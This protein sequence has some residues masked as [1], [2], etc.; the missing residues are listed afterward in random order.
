MANAGQLIVDLIAE[1]QAFRAD[2]AKASSAAQ[3]HMGSISKSI[4]GV[5]KGFETVTRVAGAFGV[6]LGAREIVDFIGR[7]IDAAARLDDMA[8]EAGVTAEQLQ[9]LTYAATQAGL[10]QDELQTALT[11]LTR[12]I[13]EA[14]N[15]SKQAIDDFD[16]LGISITDSN[17]RIRPTA[18]IYRDV[19]AGLAKIPDPAV[20][21]R[22]ETE[23]FGKSGQKLDQQLRQGAEGMDV[24][25]QKARELGLVLSDEQI[26]AMKEA[27]DK[28]AEMTLKWE[29]FTERLVS[30]VAPAIS[31]VLD[32]LNKI[33]TNITT[34]YH[35]LLAGINPGMI[36]GDITQAGIDAL[37]GG[38][39]SVTIPLTGDPRKNAPAPPSRTL[40]N[41]PEP[42]KIAGGGSRVDEAAKMVEQLRFEVDMLDKTALQQRI[43]NDLRQA[44]TTADTAYGQQI[45]ALDTQLDAHEKALKAAADA[46]QKKDELTAEGQRIH[47]SVMTPL[48][49]Y[50]AAI[51]HLSELLKAGAISQEDYNR[52]AAQLKASLDQATPAAE[53]A[54]TQTSALGDSLDSVGLSFLQ[55]AQSAKTWQDVLN[56]AINSVI[57]EILRLLEASQ[58]ASGGGGILGIL[59]SIGS[60]IGGL[61]GGGG[62]TGSSIPT[63][64]V[65]A[66]AFGGMP[67]FASGGSFMVGGMGG[68]DSNVIQF[69]ASRG[70]RVSIETPEQ[71]RR[72]HGG[73]VFAPTFNISTPDADSFRRSQRQI[74]GDGFAQ[75]QRFARR[76]GK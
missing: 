44:G 2:M 70:E 57:Q 20:R 52:K 45:T 59:G 62:L 25:I 73:M 60:A 14:A 33:P 30:D 19:A 24:A 40:I 38:D 9:G 26:K 29:R 63:G 51:A 55:S 16:Q 23:L 15:G 18:D 1:T 56:A 12:T 3:Q 48:E 13:G 39:G 76:G 35:F 27:N 7:T 37:R 42:A 28:I 67:T 49:Q 5:K 22:I 8:Q 53:A 32:L 58:G 36:A 74:V 68:L 54:A 4:D 10:S 71:Q 61:F 34:T 75:A 17:G 6:A 21:A 43:L 64:D 47:E 65:S 69:R 41:T 11:R 50:T 72:R 31:G 46:Q 66:G